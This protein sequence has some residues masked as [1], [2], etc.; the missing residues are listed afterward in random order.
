MMLATSPE[1]SRFHQAWPREA[2]YLLSKAGALSD[3]AIE[4]EARED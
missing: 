1:S 3:A 4:S 2:G